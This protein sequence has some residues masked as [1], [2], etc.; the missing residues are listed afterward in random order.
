MLEEEEFKNK[1]KKLW[2]KSKNTRQII[3]YNKEKKII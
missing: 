2:E 1:N 3:K